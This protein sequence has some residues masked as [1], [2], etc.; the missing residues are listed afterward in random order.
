MNIKVTAS[1]D[2]IKKL[3]EKFTKAEVEGALDD[4]LNDVA[5]MWYEDAHEI[6]GTMKSHIGHRTQG[7]SG[8]VFCDVDYARAEVERGG[9]HDFTA[10]G[11]SIGKALLKQKMEELL[12]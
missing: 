11:L 6:T 7:F 2:H 12:E 5:E 3:Q 10:R 4:T 1:F 8:E 9:L